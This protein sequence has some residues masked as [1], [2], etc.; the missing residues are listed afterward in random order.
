MGQSL[1]NRDIGEVVFVRS[2][3]VIRV[4]GGYYNDPGDKP[5]DTDLMEIPIPG[6]RCLSHHYA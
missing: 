6:S 2:L 5:Q 1:W 4:R 3:T